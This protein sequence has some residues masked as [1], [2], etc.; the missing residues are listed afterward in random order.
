M[1]AFLLPSPLAFAQQQTVSLTPEEQT[2]QDKTI[3]TQQLSTVSLLQVTGSGSAFIS[4][5]S[6]VEWVE[7]YSISVIFVDCL[8]GEFPVLAQQI[9]QSSDLDIL[10]S[11]AVATNPNYASWIMVIEKTN[12]DVRYSASAGVLC[13]VGSNV[14]HIGI[15]SN[16]VIL[17]QINE[18]AQ[19]FI[20]IQNNQIV[21]LDYVVNVRQQLIQNAIQIV[22]I[23]GNNNT[24]SQVINQS[25]NLILAADGTNIDQIINQTAVQAGIISPEQA[26][27]TT[28]TA[29]EQQPQEQQQQGVY[30]RTS[31][32]TPLF[33]HPNLWI[34]Y[35]K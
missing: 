17:A 13:L 25:A 26:G 28:T 20:A 1:M 18:I 6:P 34:K 5:W 27:N 3:Q 33:P 22:N 35:Q 24:V 23:T 10:Q 16:P 11:F 21:N 30:S 31:L 9:L 12:E 14:Q 7:P 29:E 4:R 8:P 19:H 2:I 32:V 15:L